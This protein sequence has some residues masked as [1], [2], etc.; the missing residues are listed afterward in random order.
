MMSILIRLYIL[1]IKQLDNINL[2]ILIKII[3]I[4][5]WYMVSELKLLQLIDH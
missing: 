3:L 5:F 2:M 4:K 1:Y